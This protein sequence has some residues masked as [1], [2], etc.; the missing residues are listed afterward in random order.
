V[1]M[2]SFDV[3]LSHRLSVVIRPFPSRGD[4]EIRQ[5]ARPNDAAE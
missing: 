4:E 3:V 5:E 2:R 1:S